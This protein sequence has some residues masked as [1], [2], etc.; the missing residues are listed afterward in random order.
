M[1]S[2][3]IVKLHLGEI[4]KEITREKNHS[5][6]LTQQLL[7]V[8]Q[9]LNPEWESA[10]LVKEMLDAE[11]FPIISSREGFR[12]DGKLTVEGSLIDFLKTAMLE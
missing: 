8:F 2:T 10:K 7:A 9:T 1:T 5:V 11:T 6:W 12:I 4:E 3:E